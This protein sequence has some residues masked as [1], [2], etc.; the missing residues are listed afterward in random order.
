VDDGDLLASF[1]AR[2]LEGEGDDALRP[3]RVMML[4]AS[5]LWL[6]SLRFWPAPGTCLRCSR[7]P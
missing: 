5:A 4:I 3:S 1:L 2:Q 7:A 6:S